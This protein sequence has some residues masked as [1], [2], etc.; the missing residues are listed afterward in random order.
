MY[1]LQAERAA[2]RASV[3]QM[4]T[5]QAVMAGTLLNVGVSLSGQGLTPYSISSFVGSGIHDSSLLQIVCFHNSLNSNAVLQPFHFFFIVH[6][7]PLFS[8]RNERMD[9]K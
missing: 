5:V 8:L 6:F 2:R 9:G 7:F 1:L 3:L 4:A